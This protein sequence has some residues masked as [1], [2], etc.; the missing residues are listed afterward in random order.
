MALPLK[1]GKIKMAH[2]IE[3]DPEKNQYVVFSEE[4]GTFFEKLLKAL[5]EKTKELAE[6]G[7]LKEPYNTKSKDK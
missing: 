3:S 7:L 5:Q 6:Q 1:K 2:E 4:K